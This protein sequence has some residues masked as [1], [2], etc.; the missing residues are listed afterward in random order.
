VK[1]FIRRILTF[2]SI[3][4][5]IFIIGLMLPATPKASTSN[6]FAK[7]SKDNLLINTSSPRIIFVGGS[8][9]SFGLNS[10]MIKDS[11]H[12]K[13]I[14]TSIHATI[15]L[16]YMMKSTLPYI[17]TGDIIVLSAEYNQ[18]YGDFAYGG[19]ELLRTVLEISPSTLGSLQKDQ[20]LNIIGYLPKYSLSKFKIKEYFYNEEKHNKDNQVYL[21]SSN[22]EFG[23]VIAHWDL[24]NERIPATK[25]IEGEFN[26]KVL[27]EIK[28]F[29]KEIRKKGAVLFVA[30]PGYQVSSFKNV[31]CEIDKV[32]LEF[33][34]NHFNILGNPSRYAFNDS[35][36]FNSAYHLTKKGLDFRTEL[37]INDLK[38]ELATSK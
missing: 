17:K 25:S 7:I 18:F 19:E 24:K 30:Y 32:E 5:L 13:P 8:N 22:N 6:L 31:K 21:V 4:L 37:L 36:L 12:L 11:L 34:K 35:M 15:G 10:Q 28:K 27:K 26:P 20:W 1:Q 16:I 23:D 33:K 29:E 38:R 14:N 2:I 3:L 9:L